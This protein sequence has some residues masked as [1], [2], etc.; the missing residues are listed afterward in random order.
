VQ[1]KLFPS[2]L[3]TAAG[4]EFAG[5]CRP[6]REVGGDYYDLLWVDD[7]HIAFALGD[8][9][10]KGL[11]PA[12]LMSNV[13]AMVRSHLRRPGAEPAALVTELNE[14]LCSSS[15]PGMFI[16]FFLGVL[17]VKTGVVRYVNGGHNP[18]LLVDGES[19]TLERLEVGGMVVGA[20]PGVPFE[21]GEAVLEPGASLTLVSDGVTEAMD[22]QGDMFGEERLEEAL[23]A[24]PGTGAKAT[25]LR[26]VESVERFRGRRELPDDLSVVV[27]HREAAGE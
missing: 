13:H 21:Q 19:A 7:D 14:H 18:G 20:M 22:E 8:V 12:L 25:M 16:T 15:A 1:Q 6:A 26:V 27:I 2:E 4:W 5:M 23:A 10:G 17:S 3:P 9:S 11:G 24:A